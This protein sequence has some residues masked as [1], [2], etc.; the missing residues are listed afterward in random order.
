MYKALYAYHDDA[1]ATAEDY[2]DCR[3]EVCFVRLACSLVV[4][5]G[6]RQ[7]TYLRCG[8]SS[9]RYDKLIRANTIAIP[10]EL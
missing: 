5:K 6:V 3:V 10:E 9:R 1:T 4:H 2:L 8:A 7:S